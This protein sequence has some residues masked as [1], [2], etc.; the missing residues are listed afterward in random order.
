MIM[1]SDLL[2]PG[3]CEITGIYRDMC[4][5]GLVKIRLMVLRYLAERGFCDL[6]RPHVTLTFEYL[7]SKVDPIDQLC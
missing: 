5:P 1:T 4:L 2:H 6:F 7:T 3:C